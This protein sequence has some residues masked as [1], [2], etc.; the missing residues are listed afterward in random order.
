MAVDAEQQDSETAQ[1]TKMSL[2]FDSS[3]TKDMHT[4]IQSLAQ[5]SGL[6]FV[7]QRMHVQLFWY[8]QQFDEARGAYQIGVY[9]WPPL[10]SR[11]SG[12]VTLRAGISHWLH[13]Q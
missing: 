10:T 3:K 12:I 1:V 8:N 7:L 2:L 4:V 6:W 9:S 11:T 13:W 5:K